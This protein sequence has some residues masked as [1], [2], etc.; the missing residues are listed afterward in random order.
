MVIVLGAILAAVLVGPVLIK[1]VERNLEVFFLCAGALAAAAGG[2]LGW[3]LLRAAAS[4]PV[5]LSLAVLGFGAVARLARSRLDRWFEKLLRTAS[6][7]AVYSIL[8]LALGLLSSVITAVVAAL[9]LVEAIALMKLDRRSEIATVVFACF[10]IGLGAALTPIG[11]PLGTIAT[12]AVA[13]DFW[14][15]MRLLGPLVVAGIA[16]VSAAA[17]LVPVARGGSLHVGRVEQSWRDVFVRAG[18][19]YVFVVG[20]VGLSWGLRPLVDAYISRI[21]AELLFWLNSIS[22][23]VDNATLT[24]AEIGPRL[25]A[26]QQRA[27]L[28]GLLISGGMLIP[29]NIPNI[30]AAGRLGI[31]SREWAAVGLVT[32][33]PLM[34]LCFLALRWIG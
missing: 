29:G 17:L 8:I 21:P 22:A 1:S 15:L 19:V 4:E 25:S 2:Q 12:A 32:G 33:L 9:F 24:A 6:P 26:A 34:A 31:G 16:I 20:L 13:K 5:A 23:V 18:K 10:A 28:M 14:Y 7:R 30:V 27:V 3:P 11:E